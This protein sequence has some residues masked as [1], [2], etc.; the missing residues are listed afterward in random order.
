MINPKQKDCNYPFKGLC[1]AAVVFKLIQELYLIFELPLESTYCLME[2]TAI[3]T[4]CDF[5]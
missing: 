4:I 1:G 2:Y 3:A 5:L